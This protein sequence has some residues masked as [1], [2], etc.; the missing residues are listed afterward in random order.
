MI[1]L[2]IHSSLEAVGFMA[3]ISTKLAEKG[4]G[5]NPV[6]GFFHDHC[7][8]PVGREEEAIRALEELVKEAKG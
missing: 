5:C 4:I 3:K 2:K 6:A 7:F 8:V 1:T